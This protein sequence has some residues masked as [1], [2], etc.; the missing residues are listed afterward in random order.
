RAYSLELLLTVSSSL[1][2][3]SAIDRPTFW[4]WAAYALVST[5]AVYAHFFA[6]W[7]LVVQFLAGMIVPG[8][9]GLRAR[10]VWAQAAVR[11]ALA[12][13]VIF[14]SHRYGALAWVP[15]PTMGTVVKFGKELTGYGSA[16]LVT[17]YLLL[18]LV[19]FLGNRGS[20]VSDE[21]RKLRWQ[22]DF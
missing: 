19:F 4:R 1:L 10:V 17:L 14:A 22:R 21:Q 6:A 13:L 18:C 11:A 9:P 15:R 3:F 2:F 20:A 12:P 7:V 8:R 16:T 5:L